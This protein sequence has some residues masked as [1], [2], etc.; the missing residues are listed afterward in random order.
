MFRWLAGKGA[1]ARDV[2]RVMTD[3]APESW[4]QAMMRLPFLADAGACTLE[5][6]RIAGGE[7]GHAA[8]RPALWDG[9]QTFA[10]SWLAHAGLLLP[11][12]KA[13]SVAIFHAKVRA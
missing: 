7:G 12:L 6:L 8:H 3:I 9:A 2:E 10:G 13:E 4:R 11:P 1:K 5:L